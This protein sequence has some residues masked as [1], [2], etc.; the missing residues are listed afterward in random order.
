VV[1]VLR[2][3]RRGEV[4]GVVSIS[5]LIPSGFGVGVRVDGELGVLRRHPRQLVCSS[6]V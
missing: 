5:V 6:L 1:K 4:R 2:L 3:V